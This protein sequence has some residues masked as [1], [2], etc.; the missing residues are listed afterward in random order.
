MLPHT[1]AVSLTKMDFSALQIAVDRALD[2]DELRVDIGLD[3]ALRADGQT[4]GMRDR[5]LDPALNEKILFCGKV[6][7]E[8]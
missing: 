3:R 7:F 1:L 6:P 2:D 4:L 5:P 8:I